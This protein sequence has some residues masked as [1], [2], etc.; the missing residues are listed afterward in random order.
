MSYDGFFRV[1]SVRILLYILFGAFLPVATAFS[2]GRSLIAGVGVKLHRSEERLFAFLVGSAAF[3]AILFVLCATHLARKGVYLVIAAVAVALAFRARP[4]ISEPADT[5]ELT[6]VWRWSFLIVVSAFTVVYFIWALAP[7]FSPDG[8][9]YHLAVVDHYSRAH[10]FER[11]PTNMY[12]NIPQGLEL[13]FLVAFAFGK[14]SAAALVHFAFLACLPWLIAFYGR[15]FG[16]PRAGMAAGVLVFAAPVVGIDGA[17]AYNDVALAAVLFG[18][19]YLL[20]VWDQERDCGLLTLIGFLTGFSVAIKY[21]AFLAPVYAV[22]FVV[23]KRW[24][25]T[26]AL[27]T[28]WR[29]VL[30]MTAVMIALAAPWL[31]KNWLWV[32]NPIAPFGNQ[33]FA[34]RWVHVSFERDYQNGLRHYELQD[35]RQIPLEVTYRGTTLGGLLGPIFLLSPLALLALRLSQGRR[36]LFA[37]ALFAVAYL[38]NIGTRFLIPPLPFLATAFAVGLSEWSGLLLAIMI[39]HAALSWPSVVGM[40]CANAAWHI[41][42]IPWA[43]ALRIEP[44]ETYLRRVWPE[45]STDRL[46]EAK[47]PAGDSV[48]LFGAIGQAY[49][50]RRMLVRYLSAPNEVLGD[51]LWTPLFI[52]FQP[53]TVTDFAFP[54]VTARKVRVVQ[55]YASTGDAWSISEMHALHGG[56]ELARAPEWRLHA[57]PNPWD[58]QL[59]FDNNPVTRWRTWQSTSPGDYVEIDF[60]S[61][62][63]LDE[64]RIESSPDYSATQTRIQVLDQNGRWI[65][66][67]GAPQVSRQDIRANMRQ[68]A[69]LE[70]K[71]R[72]IRYILV[73]RDDRYAADLRMRPSAWGLKF[74]GR[75]GFAGY[76]E[77]YRLD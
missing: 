44:E 53:I 40:Y 71:A 38:D 32:Q 21:T 63:T 70:L 56:Q 72:G 36:L 3:S 18:M 49:S 55:T 34:N 6:R 10:G 67:G 47:V 39:A 74:I 11:V 24:R 35:R 76:D 51:I 75:A 31:V 23:W 59:A 2:L 46:I 20:Q 22:G 41:D 54:P 57:N 58:V 13:L 27:Q 1:H 43:A 26:T 69:A 60:G 29:S 52:G 77:L 28:P 5:T 45:Y 37:A 61:Q 64:V 42:N 50:T 9:A 19:F 73:N 48:F 66:V 62:Q 8:T 33:I 30:V 68:A 17:S 16:F 15:R 14:H 65:A 12:F 25:R 7:E 4:R